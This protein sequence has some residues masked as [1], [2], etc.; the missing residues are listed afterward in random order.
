MKRDKLEEMEKDIRRL[1][2][3]IARQQASIEEM[4]RDRSYEPAVLLENIK[5]KSDAQKIL[6]E[7]IREYHMEELREQA[8]QNGTGGTGGPVI[9]SS[10]EGQGSVDIR[11]GLRPFNVQEGTPTYGDILDSFEKDRK[12]K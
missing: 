5:L 3:I 2:E 11:F 6:D 1:R 10:M 9:A 4:E 8:I 12:R 7:K